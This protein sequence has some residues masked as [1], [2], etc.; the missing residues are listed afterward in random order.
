[1]ICRQ[2]V[3]IISRSLDA[4]LATTER[5]G[6]RVHTLFC[7]PCRRFHRQMLHLHTICGLAD[8]APAPSDELSAAAR[9]RIAHSLARTPPGG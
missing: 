1:M 9:E 5:L 2:A 8:G 4:P 3:E 7:G 6:L